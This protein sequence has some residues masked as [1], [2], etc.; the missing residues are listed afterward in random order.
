[1]IATHEDEDPG[2]LP[3]ATLEALDAATAAIAEAVSLDAV[4]QVIADRIRPLVGARYAALGIVRPDQ[5]IARFITS[6][7]DVDTRRAIGPPPT[8]HGLLGL[9]IRER[10]SIRVDDVMSDPRRSGFPPNHPPMHSFLGVP[11]V[12]GD[13]PVGNLY[14]TEKIDA[15]RFSLADQALVETF[16]RQAA[17]AIHTAR[18]H[19][20]LEQLAVLRER[21]RIGRDLHDGIIQSLYGVGLFLEDVPDIMTSDQDEAAARV[22]R[23]IDAIHGSIRDIR[24]F[25]L[26]LHDDPDG[27]TDLVDGIRRLGEELRRASA[28]SIAVEVAPDAHQDLA[29][30]DATHDRELLSILRE[31]VSNVARHA[32]ARNVQLRL[33]TDADGLELAVID[34]GRG[35]D[36]ARATPGGHHGIANM[37]ARATAVGATLDLTSE[38]GSGTQVRLRRPWPQ[39][40]QED[41]VHDA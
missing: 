1:M 13:Q 5:R 30:L 26:G 18:L 25:I 17:M 40:E 28:A 27:G 16:A 9:L 6:G 4:L 29:R 23:A 31:A 22:D 19:A 35:F 11:V 12:L 32:G 38:P 10:R 15:P 37:R 14:L 20:D 24:G 36:A 34:D 21:E 41:D 8:G 33:S 7:M 2:P 39:A 3:A